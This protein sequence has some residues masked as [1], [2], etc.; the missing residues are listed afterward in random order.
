MVQR[1]SVP[2][3]K[4]VTHSFILT[5]WQRYSHCQPLCELFPSSVPSLVINMLYIL[6][7]GKD[8]SPPELEKETKAFMN[9]P[10]V[11][12]NADFSECVFPGS[13]IFMQIQ[14]LKDC[15]R[16]FEWLVDGKDRKSVWKTIHGSLS[17]LFSGHP[18]NN[19]RREIEKYENI[20]GGLR[21][22]RFMLLIVSYPQ[23]YHNSYN[24]QFIID[25]H[26]HHLPTYITVV[27]NVTMVILQKRHEKG[28]LRRRD[29]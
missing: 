24:H 11:E 16:P 6:S 17:L 2:K 4:A 1:A 9:S 25:L 14:R 23:P 28:V 22:A 19:V 10:S 27:V 26:Y 15:Q 7:N 12:P 21:F 3:M 5:G 13:E 20:R 29:R 8:D 18:R